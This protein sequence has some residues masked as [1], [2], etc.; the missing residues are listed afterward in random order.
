MCSPLE[1]FGTTKYATARIG[2]S[3]AW[4]PSV[5]HLTFEGHA[6]GMSLKPQHVQRYRDIARLFFKYGRG[7]LLKNAGFDA[8]DSS[9]E[10][11]PASAPN[12][13]ATAQDGHGATPSATEPDP[14]LQFAT[15]L[16]IL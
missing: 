16:E 3:I 1:S 8:A 10:A 14:G 7:D 11:A 13:T 5:L 4:T 6:M 2:M 12:A 9:I 15:D